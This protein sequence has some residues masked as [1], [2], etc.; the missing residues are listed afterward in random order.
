MSHEDNMQFMQDLA[1]ARTMLKNLKSTVLDNH[2][3]W[4]KLNSVVDYLDNE[5]VVL[6][7]KTFGDSEPFNPFRKLPVVERVS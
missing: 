1:Q 3:A 4:T 2:Y 5:Q 6:G 7:R